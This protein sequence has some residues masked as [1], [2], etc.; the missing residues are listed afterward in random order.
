MASHRYQQSMDSQNSYYPFPNNNSSTANIS[1]PQQDY[2]PN[3]SY[4]MAS[5]GAG[6][7]AAA[8]RPRKWH[9]NKWVRYGLPAVLVAIIVAAVVGGIEASKNDDDDSSSNSNGIS[10]NAAENTAAAGRDSNGNPVYAT[11]GTSSASAPAA[12]SSSLAGLCQTDNPDYSVSGGDLN[13][14]SDHPRLFAA[15]SKWNC[16]PSQIAQDAYLR[17]WNAT[18]FTNATR[19]ANM[20]PVTYDVDGG[21]SGSGIL[22]VARELQL[23][24][25]HWAYAYR[26]SNDSSW[27]E[28]TW[29][30]LLVASGNS[31]QSFG[32]D[33]TRW[34][35]QHFL[36][37][38]EMTL[39]FA[40]AYD[41]MYDAWSADQR[42][43]IM[44]SIVNLG[45]SFGLRSYTESTGYGWWQTTNGNWNCV[46]NGGLTLGALAVLGDDPTG[47][48]AELLT[49]T[50]PNAQENC[51][52]AVQPDGTWTET[53][54]YWYFGSSGH[55]QMAA[56]LKTA[57]GSTQQ[58]LSA[59]PN[60]NKT[61]LFHMYGTGFVQKFNYGDCGPNKYTA[62]ANCMMFYG[63]EFDIPVYSLYQRDRSDA[64]EPLS[65][66]YYNPDTTGDWWYNLP[67]DHYF[68]NPND[69]WASFRSSWTDTDG[70]YSAI[71]AGNLTGHQTHGDLDIGDFVIEAMG[72]RWAGELCQAN[73]LEPGYFSSEAQDSDR[74][75][76]YRCATEG[77]NT[78]VYNG[79]NQLVTALPPTNYDS[80]G[81]EQSSLTYTPGSNSAAYFWT[82]MTS[83]YNADI[84]RGLRLLNSRRQILV[85]DEFTGTAESAEWRMQT[86]ATITYSNDQRTANLALNGQ[87]MTVQILASA[88]DLTF[89]TEQ[90]LR[91]DSLGPLP[92]GGSD[93]PTPVAESG[94]S[95]LAIEI[96]AGTTTL[97][98]LFN[99]QWSGMASSAF[100][101]PSS[102][103]LSSWS[104]TSHSS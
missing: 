3:K 55:S 23:R 57:T 78:I 8:A 49:H 39:G 51:A 69:A 70:L 47:T 94:T 34:N 56:G 46:C 22:D 31:S 66:F 79:Q 88:P 30:E 13:V 74:W 5:A 19:Y 38:A 15:S 32:A 89:N 63:E 25:K 27:V 17:S 24:V 53:S 101:T 62:T 72:Q 82:D 97:E 11:S 44:W 99:P 95:V 35:P 102:V 37:V 21:L 4:P 59:N 60:Y 28:R 92:S 64:P 81:D 76:Y 91:T 83:A 10:N 33:G 71:K 68:S 54:D 67:I 100:V 42:N 26:L 29:Q 87:T 20:D 18:I 7:G 40:Y 77:Q 65:M 58:L 80:T 86:N 41:W 98:V 93:N 50:V 48:A 2:P 52:M 9:Q 61:G 14:R 104:L 90:A 16:L 45:L 12:T 84:K 103:P 6:Y 85:Q 96:P 73:Y 75:D 43:A 36:D 1:Y